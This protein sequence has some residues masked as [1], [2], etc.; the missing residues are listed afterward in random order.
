MCDILT[1]VSEF[2]LEL[3]ATVSAGRY[4]RETSN[5]NRTSNDSRRGMR[6][7]Q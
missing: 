1:A 2:F 5:E 3:T 7:A 6:A 4:I